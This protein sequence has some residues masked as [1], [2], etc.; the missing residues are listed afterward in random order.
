M[1]YQSNHSYNLNAYFFIFLFRKFP[2][3]ECKVYFI[4]LTSV[5]IGLWIDLFSSIIPLQINP[6]LSK[7]RLSGCF[8]INARIHF[9]IFFLNLF[10][11]FNRI[12]VI[13][14][15]KQR[16]NQKIYASHPWPRYFIAIEMLT[17]LKIR[18]KVCVI[19]G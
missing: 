12:I 1:C 16:N 9:C 11:I 17:R 3:I 7:I 19:I 5:Y 4:D 6:E 18:K 10:K 2:E 14:Y 13:V 8:F 15:K